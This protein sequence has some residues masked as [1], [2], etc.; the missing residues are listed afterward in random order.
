MSLSTV[1]LGFRQEPEHLL[2]GLCKND[3]LVAWC[4]ELEKR[5][6]PRNAQ[7]TLYAGQR[8]LLALAIGSMVQCSNP[9]SAS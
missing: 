2:T 3:T 4:D 9:D 5:A 1:C 8:Q 7:I 6:L